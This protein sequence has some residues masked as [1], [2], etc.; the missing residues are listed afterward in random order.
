MDGDESVDC[1]GGFLSPGFFDCHVHVTIDNP[2]RMRIIETPFSL[3]FFQAAANLRRTLLAGV[4]TVRDAGG[5]D[6]G[7]VRADQGGLREGQSDESE[8]EAAI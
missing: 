4:T 8:P 7:I 5:A 2:S 6:L 1:S 3:Q